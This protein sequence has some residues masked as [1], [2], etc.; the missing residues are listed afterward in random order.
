MPEYPKRKQNRLSGYNYALNGAYHVTICTKN[1]A[2]ILSSIVGQAALC[3]PQTQLTTI[4]EIVKT[5]IDRIPKVYP[6]ILVEKYVIMPN[7]VHILFRI[8][9]DG[10]QRAALPTISDVV[11]SLKI[12]VRKKTGRSLFQTSYHDH[13][14]RCDHD[15]RETYQYIENNPTRWKTR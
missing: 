2:P 5:Y 1:K 8:E 6:H 14:I 13:I 10:V 7:H 11:R 4:G 9:T 15:Y 3:L 12:M